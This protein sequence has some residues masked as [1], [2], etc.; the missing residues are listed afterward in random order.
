MLRVSSVN[1][2]V[3][4]RK[5]E[6]EILMK[7]CIELN[8]NWMNKWHLSNVNQNLP[9]KIVFILDCLTAHEES[10]TTLLRRSCYLLVYCIVLM[11]VCSSYWCKHSKKVLYANKQQL[12]H[13]D[14][15]LISLWHH[16]QK[17]ANPVQLPT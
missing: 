12:Y 11:L 2:W 10:N 4:E 16:N 1:R 6:D 8:D 14:V 5:S 3:I 17:I 15:V 7:L 9:N 13:S